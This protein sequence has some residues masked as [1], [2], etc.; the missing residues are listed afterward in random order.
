P[1][2]GLRNVTLG[3]AAGLIGALAVM[4]VVA[5]SVLGLYLSA[6]IPLAYQIVS[7][8]NLIVFAKT[9][10]YRFFRT[11]ELGLSLVLPFALQL[12][13]GGFVPSSGVV[14]WSFT[15]PLGALLFSGR[16]E[17]SRWFGAFVVVIG[18]SAA[19]DP[20]LANK[21]AEIPRGLVIAFFA[22]NVLG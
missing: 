4:W 9:R 10:R 6:A 17:A 18:L 8:S 16:R 14:L 5:H 7:L 20:F 2:G 13:L 19:L 15:A 11:C 21:T 22:L 12:S 1:D 3:L